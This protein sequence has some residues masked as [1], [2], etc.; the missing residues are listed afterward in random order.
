[1]AVLAIAA[2]VGRPAYGQ[3]GTLAPNDTPFG[4]IG[5]I[6]APHG[7]GVV[8]TNVATGAEQ[9]MAVMPP[10]GVAGHAAWSP[11]RMQLAISRFGRRPSERVGGSDILVVSA[12]GGEA[13]SV[14][15]HDVDGALLG[16]P[17]WLPDGS[18]I[19]YDHLPPSGGTASTQVMFAHNRHRYEWP[20]GGGRQLAGSLAGWPAARRTSGHRA[21]LAT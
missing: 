9:A 4:P 16:S 11:D 15:E 12:V 10:V 6:A 19:F 21:R 13:L 20:H 1:M 2:L 3:I 18:G 17:A 5:T 8:L 14:A 7:A